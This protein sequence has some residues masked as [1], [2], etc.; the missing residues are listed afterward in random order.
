MGR[1]VWPIRP[2]NV[3][4]SLPLEVWVLGPDL[5][6]SAAKNELE[7]GSGA[8]HPS[9]AGPMAVKAKE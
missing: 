4:A 5:H 3:N 8:R 1:S 2:L 9:A 6:E 7:A